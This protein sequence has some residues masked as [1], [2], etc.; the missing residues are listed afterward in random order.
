MSSL[1]ANKVKS[2]MSLDSV[3]LFVF[4]TITVQTYITYTTITIRT[5]FLSAYNLFASHTCT[6]FFSHDY[7]LFGSQ[8]FLQALH[9]FVRSSQRRSS[10]TQ[11][12]LQTRLIK[13]LLTRSMLCPALLY[14]HVLSMQN[15]LKIKGSCS[16]LLASIA[17]TCI[18]VFSY[19]SSA[20][21]W[22][23]WKAYLLVY[24]LVYCQCA[25]VYCVHTTSC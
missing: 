15:F 22:F 19:L 8:Y 11:P 24:L 1:I 13:L 18:C 23:T 14:M 5:L 17:T 10:N 16:R 12:Q 20:C 7:S 4:C 21:C 25:F 9:L 2:N 3:K 6:L